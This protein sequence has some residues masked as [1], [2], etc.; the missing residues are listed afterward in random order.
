LVALGYKLSGRKSDSFYAGSE[1][2]NKEGARTST[3]PE[4][5]NTCEKRYKTEFSG[6]EFHSPGRKF[7]KSRNLT[8]SASPLEEG[9]IN[10]NAAESQKSP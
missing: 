3:P 4:T 6:G 7:S 9:V 1:V 10:Q 8:P 5:V 2:E